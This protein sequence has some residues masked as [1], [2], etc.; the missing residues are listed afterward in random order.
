MCWDGDI[1]PLQAK[2]TLF[3]LVFFSALDLYALNIFFAS[4]YVVFLSGIIWFPEFE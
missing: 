2:L 3:Q 1:V 4:C